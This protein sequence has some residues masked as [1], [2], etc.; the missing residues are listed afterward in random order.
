MLCRSAGEHRRSNSESA[1][2]GATLAALG[3]ST[4]GKLA[5]ERGSGAGAAD[6]PEQAPHVVLTVQ[7]AP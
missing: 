6:S 5:T 3:P 4:L 1:R 2:P 7:E